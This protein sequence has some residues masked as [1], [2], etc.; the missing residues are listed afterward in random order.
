M[1]KICPIASNGSSTGFAPI[2]VKIT[3]IAARD[4]NFIFLK[5]L[6]FDLVSLFTDT[7]KIKI[8]ARRAMTPPSFEGIE[9]RIA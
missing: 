4:Q 9:R 8:E 2:Q 5:G 6:N 3:R 1:L 7:A